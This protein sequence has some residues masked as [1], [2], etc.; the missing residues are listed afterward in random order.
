MTTTS[1]V[2]SNQ[3][4][5]QVSAGE[6]LTVNGG[7]TITSTTISNG[8]TVSVLGGAIDS[9]ATIQSGGSEMVFGSAVGDQIYGTQTLSSA[10]ATAINET[11]YNGGSLDIFLKLSVASGVTVDSG[12][13]IQINGSAYTSNT[14]LNGGGLI[15]LE[16]TQAYIAGTVTMYGSGNEIELTKVL[17]GAEATASTTLVNFASGDTIVV[18]GATAATVTAGTGAYAGDALVTASSGTASDT[19][20]MSNTAVSAVSWALTS[21]TVSG[22][23]VPVET[24]SFN[25][26]SNGGGVITS[27]TTPTPAGAF[28]ETAGNTLLVLGGGSVSAATIS[29]SGALTVSGGAD[30]AATVLSGGVE[31]VLSGSASGDKISGTLSASGATASISNETVFNGG[32]I[33]LSG[34]TVS[35]VTLSGGAELELATSGATV[36]GALTFTGGGNEL[37]VSGLAS[38]GAGELAVISGF[39]TTDTIV[40]APINAS[41]ATLAFSATAGGNDMATVS[42]GAAVESFVFSGATASSTILLTADSAGHAELIL[43]S[44]VTTVSTATTSAYTVGA[45]QYLNV[46]AGG[47]VSAVTVLSGGNLVISSGG[48]DASATV[49]SGGNE[50]VSGG[51]SATGDAISGNLMVSG[52]S[53]SGVTV[54]AAT[55]SDETI[56]AG[57]NV[58]LN[59]GAV[60]TG[61]VL[62]AGATMLV[63]AV[64]GS[65]T[66]S[67]DSIYGT[68]N[69]LSGLA[70]TYTDETVYNG[71]FLNLQNANEGFN[72]VVSSGG[73]LTLS[74]KEYA[75]N[76]VLAGGATVMLELPKA[77]LSSGETDAG[78]ATPALTFE[79][80]N[81]T[82]SITNLASSGS[83]GVSGTISGFGMTDQV[84][85]SGGI[86]ASAFTL[87]ADASGNEVLTVSSGG[88]TD[89]LT[90][91]GGAGASGYTLGWTASG[92]NEVLTYVPVI[93]PS[94]STSTTSGAYTLFGGDSVTVAAGGSVSAVT[95]GFE[96]ELIVSGGVDSGADILS[97]GLETVTTGSASGDMIYGSAVV[98]GGVVSGETVF[99][100]GEMTVN[101]SASAITVSGGGALDLGGGT[102]NNATLVSGGLVDLTDATATLTGVVTFSGGGNTLEVDAISNPGAG[103]QAVI[104]GFSTADK[105]DVKAISP[106]GVSSSFTANSDGTET[107]TINGVGG[108]ESFIFDNGTY[109]SSTM[110]LIKDGS[111]GVDLIEKTTPVV[112][113][114]SLNNLADNQSPGVISTNQATDVVNGTVNVAVDPEAVGTTVTVDEGG[115]AVGTATVQ[116]NGYWSA[117][118]TFQND[119]GANVLTATDTDLAQQTGVTATSLTYNVNTAAAAFTAGDLVISVYGDGSGSGNYSLD[120]A[121]PISLDE[122]TTSGTIVSQIVLP[123][124]TTTVNGVSEPWTIVNGVKEYTISGEYGS[125]SEGALQLSAD[126]Q[127]LTIMGYGVN[128]QAFDASNSNAVYGSGGA[129]GQSISL[130]SDTAVTTVPRVVA[131]I[132]ASGA[133]DTSTGLTNIYDSNNPRSVATV[134]GTAFYLSGQGV[135]GSANQGVFYATDG[136]SSATAI[137]TATDTRIAEIYNGQLYVS[138]NSTQGATNITDY[139]S[140]GP[141]NT[142]TSAATATPV[143]LNGIGP[144]VTLGAGNGNAINA[145]T[146]TVYLSPESF[147]FANSTTLYVADG[148]LP[149][150]GGVGDGGLQKWSDVGGTW[151]LDYTLNNGLSLVN[152]TTVGG[153]GV[154]GLYGLTGEVVNGQ[155]ELYATSS[156]QNELDASDLYSISNN[157]ADTTA[158]QASGETFTTLM[159]NS[160]SSNE[161]IRGVS[162]APTPCYCK[163]TLIATERGEVA[164]EDLAIGDLVITLDGV[165]KPIKWIG[166]R[167]YDGRFVG[168]NHEVLPIR[169]RAGA[170]DKNIPVRDLWVSPRHAL[171]L[172]GVL[173]DAKDL[174]N[175]VSIT[176]ARKVE[177]VDYFH[178]ELFEHD[179]LFAEGRR[180]NP[181]S[182][183]TAARCSSMRA[184]ISRFIRKPKANGARFN[185]SRR[186]ATKVSRSKRR[187]RKLR[188]RPASTRRRER[189]A[190][191]ADGSKA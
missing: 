88:L 57:G 112:T 87:G 175:G 20:I 10:G 86:A 149:K 171:Y 166:T 138:A 63:S 140:V 48:Q 191:L 95:A 150:N 97:G 81:N 60:D 47:S 158:A 2:T 37:L 159:T 3:S 189:R 76:T 127:S 75:E 118:V 131:D 24:L 56:S 9:G 110:T 122:I 183:M 145:S 67:G 157:L 85:V 164:V 109:N 49:Q 137:S 186:G 128:Y 62:E 187:E 115:S 146:G 101:G 12:G 135:K 5:L 42:S 170:L 106:T 21:V 144:T 136:A 16:S 29:N 61:M 22:A 108:S 111:G 15:E 23:T 54:S 102:V 34:A 154:T 33:V 134:N 141:V 44:G 107:V 41:G 165:A 132:N 99:S 182:T 90:F 53:V 70:A 40:V 83:G 121:A 68:V 4:G 27:V 50:T 1:T 19:F 125:A 116:A 161:I 124:T 178:I 96:G 84:V 7:V 55:I 148:G 177:R 114:T 91:S 94:V 98:N 66:L 46:V 78:A 89:I 6:T 123:E 14:T 179:I 169:I 77:L 173:I 167:S 100:G 26:V 113:F 18:S 151:T 184:T 36:S 119:S 79:N 133:I 92:G 93:S 32:Q 168:A 130:T 80:G 72:I 105:I 143:V 153:S 190:P 17:S 104:S 180:L 163:G 126:G 82:L 142:V 188:R 51:G 35:G 147:F 162:F 30:V 174:V 45:D 185:P 39:S 59:A 43:T 8:G 74:G 64:S 69:T 38:A 155:V 11:V 152:G 181:S 52:A 172:E 65:A 31:S 156:T 160:A 120:Q 25:A 73:T 129:L 139:G 28:T 103:D 117:N 13:E 176:Q 58:T 71:G